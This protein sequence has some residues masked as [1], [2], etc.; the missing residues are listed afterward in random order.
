MGTSTANMNNAR[1][2]RIT[3]LDL[4]MLL[5]KYRRPEIDSEEFA[6]VTTEGTSRGEEPPKKK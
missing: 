5:L 6:R 2:K 4:M 3:S 1:K